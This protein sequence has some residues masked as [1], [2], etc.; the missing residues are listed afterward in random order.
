MHI[1]GI[2]SSATAAPRRL[3]Q[4]PI[5]GGSTWGA[6]SSAYGG[7]VQV[8]SL[9]R[10]AVTVSWSAPP[11]TQTMAN[12]G[13]VDVNSL[14]LGAMPGGSMSSFVTAVPA[15]SL[16]R[17]APGP[18]LQQY[19]VVASPV[20]VTAPMPQLGPMPSAMRDTSSMRMSSAAAPAPSLPLAAA[21]ELLANSARAALPALASVANSAPSPSFDAAGTLMRL[22][23]Q[24]AGRFVSDAGRAVQDAGTVISK[25]LPGIVTAATAVS[26]VL[27]DPKVQRFIDTTT[28]ALGDS[29]RDLDFELPSLGGGL[30]RFGGSFTP[31]NVGLTRVPG[32]SGVSTASL[33]KLPGF[34]SLSLPR[35]PGFGGAN[36]A[37]R[38]AHSDVMLGRPAQQNAGSRSSAAA[39]RVSAGDRQGQQPERQQQQ[40]QRVKSDPEIPQGEMHVFHLSKPQPQRQDSTVRQVAPTG[41]GASQTSSARSSDAVAV[42]P[43]ASTP[44]RAR[45]AAS[46]AGTAAP[47][48]PTPSVPIAAKLQQHAAFPG[49]MPTSPTVAPLPAAA[50][51]QRPATP[52]PTADAAIAV[53]APMPTKAKAT[54][55]PA[56]VASSADSGVAAVR[57]SAGS[58]QGVSSRRAAGRQAAAAAAAVATAEQPATV[59]DADRNVM[60]KVIDG[61]LVRVE[62]AASAPFVAA[63][64][65]GSTVAEPSS[66]AELAASAADTALKAD[67]TTAAAVDGTA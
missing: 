21:G 49:V 18:M 33:P 66:T 35:I 64:P 67:Q 34:D 44:S 31:A 24:N 39:R 53:A 5:P 1:S 41:R 57:R 16:L 2:C 12:G 56:M 46:S 55:S 40:M 54:L 43:A 4:L 22:F 60:F 58:L 50:G 30:Q 38:A 14:M 25:N 7:A 61:R 29:V 62:A 9:P 13:S 65:D 15:N 26:G 19:P 63:K 52:Q 23:E 27:S 45:V 48:K 11:V 3:A 32:M 10:E 6:P 37:A 28:A 8:A 51:K 59:G 20:A 36:A 47:V 17:T 42:E